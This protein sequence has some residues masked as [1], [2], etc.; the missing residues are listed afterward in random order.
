MK[1]KEED[2][3]QS[4]E[5]L[6]PGDVL[7]PRPDLIVGQEYGDYYLCKKIFSFLNKPVTVKVRH[8][9]YNDFL[10][11]EAD[12]WLPPQMFLKPTTSPAHLTSFEGVEVGDTLVVRDDLVAGEEYGRCLFLKGEMS[13]LIGSLVT[14]NSYHYNRS[15]ICIKEC[16]YYWTPEMF[17]KHIPKNNKTTEVKNTYQ[18]SPALYTEAICNVCSD[19]KI[20]LIEWAVVVDGDDFIS[21]TADQVLKMYMEVQK[22][23]SSHLQPMFKQMFPDFVPPEPEVS[24][25]DLVFAAVRKLGLKDTQWLNRYLKVTDDSVYVSCEVATSTDSTPLYEFLLLVN[26]Q[27][28]KLHSYTSPGREGAWFYIKIKDKKEFREFLK[29]IIQ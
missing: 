11:E 28:G 29:S 15:R 19:W 27:K 13:S 3:L 7:T 20:N 17:S 1:V 23:I 9:R 26:R 6:E 2:I 12:Y 18:I 22:P 10:A 8:S 14:V 4:V 24:T 16:S 21:Y 25:E 5:G